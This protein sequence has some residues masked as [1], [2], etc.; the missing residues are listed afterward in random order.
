MIYPMVLG[1]AVASMVFS[2]GK[3]LGLSG[4]QGMY[5]FYGLALAF[6]ILMGFFKN[7]TDYSKR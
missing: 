3:A 2:G 7:K 6:T 4:L 1:L 5:A